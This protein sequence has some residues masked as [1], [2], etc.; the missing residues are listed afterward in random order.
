MNQES[1]PSN[2]IAYKGCGCLLLLM[3]FGMI[4]ASVMPSFMRQAG[5]AKQVEPKQYVRSMNRVQ[6][7]RFAEKGAFA[8]SVNALEMGIKTE[9]SNGKY[10]VIAT[11]TTAFNYGLSKKKDFKSCVGGVFVVHAKEVIPNAVKDEIITISIL[12][13]SDSPGTIEPAEPTYQNGKLICGQGT[14]EVTK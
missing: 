8:T 14:T 11:K 3:L 12:C 2:S 4:V 10:S 1:F 6:H 5:K 13:Q 9:T 7:A